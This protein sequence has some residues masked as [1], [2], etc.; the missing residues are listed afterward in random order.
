MNTDRARGSLPGIGEETREVV[1]PNGKSEVVHTYGWYLRKL[2][3]D[4]KAKGATPIVLSLTV[5]N[6][7][8]DGRVERGSGKFG[9][10]AAAVAAS[11]SVA[12]VDLTRIVADQYEKLGQQNV[13][14]L[15]AADHTHTSPQGAERGS[16]LRDQGCFE[17]GRRTAAARTAARRRCRLHA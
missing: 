13:A 8:Q 16:F 11:Q 6:I 12:F 10:W 14:A 15:F 3:A 17:V 7:W 5:R 1:M 2:I 4:T 9:E